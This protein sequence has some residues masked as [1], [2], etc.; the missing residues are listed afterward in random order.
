MSANGIANLAALRASLT[1]DYSDNVKHAE[2]HLAGAKQLSKLLSVGVDLFGR[3]GQ[4]PS[5]KHK[6]VVTKTTG[7]I[8]QPGQRAQ[9]PSNPNSAKYVSRAA[10][11]PSGTW[12]TRP[13]QLANPPSRA[14]ADAVPWGTTLDDASVTSS[15]EGIGVP[16][17]KIRAPRRNRS[18]KEVQRE[19]ELYAMAA[20]KAREIAL[21]RR[22]VAETQQQEPVQPQ[23]GP[24]Q[25]VAFA[26]TLGPPKASAPA[27]SSAQGSTARRG[28]GDVPAAAQRDPPTHRANSTHRIPM[29]QKANPAFFQA[30]SSM[31]VEPVV[32]VPRP[33]S[34]PG[35]VPQQA[36]MV[37]QVH[38]SS[39]AQEAEDM[40][41]ENG[42]P[43]AADEGGQD[44]QL[45]EDAFFAAEVYDAS[46]SLQEDG[47]NEQG[48]DED[49]EAAVPAD[50]AADYAAASAE[51][52]QSILFDSAAMQVAVTS[53]NSAEESFVLA[54]EL[55][56]HEEEHEQQQAGGQSQGMAAEAS[57]D[58]RAELT[59]QFLP[60]DEEGAAPVPVH[61]ERGVVLMT[62]DAGGEDDTGEGGVGGVQEEVDVRP[63]L[64][65]A[66][67]ARG[68][69]ATGRGLHMAAPPPVPHM[70][71][72]GALDPEAAAVANAP[73][74]FELVARHQTRPAG[75]SSDR[76]SAEP[77]GKRRAGRSAEPSAADPF[78]RRS[79]SSG[80]GPAHMASGVYSLGGFV[81]AGLNLADTEQEQPVLPDPV[82]MRPAGVPSSLSDPDRSAQV[83]EAE[84]E[85]G[86]DQAALARAIGAAGA[87]QS[88]A[89]SDAGGG[90]RGAGRQVYASTIRLGNG[91]N[92]AWALQADQYKHTHHHAVAA[93]AKSR[94]K[95]GTAKV[96]LGGSSDRAATEVFMS[97]LRPDAPAHHGTMQGSGH[98]PGERRSSQQ[99]T[100]G[101]ALTW[102][103]PP[104][105][106][107]FGSFSK[108][109][110]DYEGYRV[111]QP[112]AAATGAAYI[113][114]SAREAAQQ[115]LRVLH[116]GDVPG[117]VGTG[118][119]SFSVFSGPSL[120]ASVD[121]SGMLRSGLGTAGTASTSLP[122]PSASLPRG[123][124]NADPPAV[125]TFYNDWSVPA[126]AALSGGYAHARG[127]VH[128]HGSG[129]GREPQ[130]K[131]KEWVLMRRRST[132]KERE[133]Q[134][135]GPDDVPVVIG[136][137]KG[138]S[139]EEIEASGFAPAPAAMTAGRHA[140][141]STSAAVHASEAQEQQEPGDGWSLSA[142]S[143]ARQ[144]E[145]DLIAST[146]AALETATLLAQ[147][148]LVPP[149]ERQA[150][151]VPAPVLPPSATAAG[152]SAAV[153]AQVQLDSI[154]ARY[155]QPHQPLGE[156]EAM[157]GSDE[158]HSD[159]VAGMPVPAAWQPPQPG[160]VV[161]Q[162][163]VASFFQR[164]A[165]VGEFDTDG[166]GEPG[167]AGAG[168]GDSEDGGENRSMNESY[169]LRDNVPEGASSS[170]AQGQM[171]HQGREHDAQPSAGSSYALAAAVDVNESGGAG[172][173]GPDGDGA[174][175]AST[176]V[177][178][179][180]HPRNEAPP[181]PEPTVIP[182][183]GEN[184]RG[185]PP[186]TVY[187]QA[188][189]GEEALDILDAIMQE[190]EAALA[191]SGVSDGS[192]LFSSTGRHS[193]KS[194]EDS[195]ASSD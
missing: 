50:A 167:S 70:Q 61:E 150:L 88:R 2:S 41:L 10:P 157:H 111:R 19:A 5:R 108:L 129:V 139:A 84:W 95:S 161:T 122:A 156:P 179:P 169:A 73:A 37:V 133:A 141:Q 103:V 100:T 76:L 106:A 23:Q 62:S 15:Q 81:G 178:A 127:H 123:T 86:T 124:A 107:A 32:L 16:I 114:T 181:E 109:A 134:S 72:E 172:R 189:G 98:R 83:E 135:M 71:H 137:G 46:M 45:Y 138:L 188:E 51:A 104:T 24:R 143:S 144:R 56:A 147:Y 6:Q 190:G 136:P 174:E 40:D 140:R 77:R 183:T 180:A 162:A 193:V 28:R 25:P 21:Q 89:V 132:R 121:V 18:A 58:L 4:L 112:I 170:E 184:G 110:Y 119:A 192:A 69:T 60:E 38:H 93:Q 105:T 54:E 35:A 44:S 194:G 151:P 171:L 27:L 11:Q 113:S 74:E 49:V 31:P 130:S 57:Y 120:G 13:R 65:P 30:A 175:Q 154:P 186:Q 182:R 153:S 155:T 36:R 165:A 1:A 94:S 14:G 125:P 80:P 12:Y 142:S 26:V 39:I 99:K 115:A 3:V 87:T 131:I 176:E 177:H 47:G 128:G 29:A 67:S 78:A 149:V 7:V 66:L 53:A 185:V 191:R 20:E 92:G 82:D 52:M 91:T 152:R 195:P 33:A 17:S 146:A 59:E 8:A 118:P 117:A 145:L 96:A 22:W 48:V 68:R 148:R 160:A 159:Q 75:V 90:S 9:M 85:P 63:L 173:G 158:T 164:L 187:A 64:A 126:S 163:D 102:N 97:V 116:G 34:V 43:A 101:S 166:A 168:R 42:T 55:D 79:A